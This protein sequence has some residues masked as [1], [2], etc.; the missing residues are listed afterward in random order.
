MLRQESNH[1]R[2]PRTAHHHPALHSHHRTSYSC[3]IAAWAVAAT[4][5]GAFAYYR[6]RHDNAVI[7][8]RAEIV[9]LNEEKKKTFEAQRAQ[10]AAAVEPPPP[11]QQQR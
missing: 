7:M 4:I 6:S 2:A 10:E 8:S 9:A 11:S 1:L 5:A 3:S